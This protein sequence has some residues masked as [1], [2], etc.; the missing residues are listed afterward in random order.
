MAACMYKK[1]QLDQAQM[2]LQTVL[3]EVAAQ[4][5]VYQLQVRY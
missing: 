1:Q 3:I 2:A 5:F 4:R